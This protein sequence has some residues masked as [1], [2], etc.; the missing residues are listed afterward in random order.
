MNTYKIF[1]A[2]K[3]LMSEFPIETGK[4]SREAL[5]K[6]LESINKSDLKVKVSSSNYVRFGL[7]QVTF[8]DGTMYILGGKRQV[9]FEVMN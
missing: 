9:W 1:D 6:Y 7:Q 4:T 8:K 3:P 5:S 2:N